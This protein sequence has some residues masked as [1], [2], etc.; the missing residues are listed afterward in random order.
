MATPAGIESRDYSIEV[1]Q[2]RIE[3]RDK[4][5]H[6]R[7][8]KIRWCGTCGVMGS[9]GVVGIVCGC[10]RNLMLPAFKVARCH[11]HKG[12]GAVRPR[13][14][15]RSSG[16]VVSW[17]GAASWELRVAVNERDGRRS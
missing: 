1:L 14:V 5:C 8:M 12:K 2:P 7:W 11:A 9:C 17:V 10:G 15:R 16:G 6:S 13:G 4:M 3:S